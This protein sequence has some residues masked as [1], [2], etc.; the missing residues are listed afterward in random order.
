MKLYLVQHGISKPKEEDP[1]QPLTLE[2]R[3]E[4]K[5]IAEHLASKGITVNVIYYSP[6][7]R[8]KETGE[9]FAEALRP[10]TLQEDD[11]LK[12]L[13]DVSVWAERL[14]KRDDHIMLV[15]HLPHLQKLASLLLTGEPERQVVGFRNAGVVC[16]E[17]TGQE[18]QLKWALL[19][20]L[21]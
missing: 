19:P 21:L 20:E 6:K 13:D 7:L 15:G 18:W 17:R 3:A 2:G 16:L 1:Q 5:R 4:A 10:E 12:P 9:I 14:Q 8:A 11:T